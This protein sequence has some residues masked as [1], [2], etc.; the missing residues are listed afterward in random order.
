MIHISTPIADKNKDEVTPQDYNI[1]TIK[2]GPTSRRQEVEEFK[3][4]SA[5]IL[6]RLAKEVQA[7]KRLKKENKEL[8]KYLQNLMK[9]CSP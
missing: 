6:E 2:L 7:K 8:N 3:G 9:P 5:T 1:Q 4:P